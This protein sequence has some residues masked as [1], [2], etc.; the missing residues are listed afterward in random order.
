MESTDVKTW[1]IVQSKLTFTVLIPDKIEWNAFWMNKVYW[2]VYGKCARSSNL[3]DPVT[4]SELTV[5]FDHVSTKDQDKTH[6]SFHEAEGYLFP[7]FTHNATFPKPS[8]WTR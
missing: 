8:Q 1:N 5:V 7:Q 2:L 3:V 6:L 4:D